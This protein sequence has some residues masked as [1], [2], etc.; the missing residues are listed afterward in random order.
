MAAIPTFWV[1]FVAGLVAFGALVGAM[2]IGQQFTQNVL[3]Y[4]PL[5]AVLLT[6]ALAIGMVPLRCLRASLLVPRALG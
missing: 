3:M 4:T 6:L 5:H 2:F 1:A